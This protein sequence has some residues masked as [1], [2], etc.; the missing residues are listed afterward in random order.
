[1][2]LSFFVVTDGQKW[3]EKLKENIERERLLLLGDRV[4]VKKIS[5]QDGQVEGICV[6][7][8]RISRPSPG[9]DSNTFHHILAAN[10]DALVIVV[11]TVRP[12]F[13]AGLIDR[14]LIGAE[15]E[16][17]PVII[18]V[19]KTDLME[20]PKPWL[21]YKTLGYEVIEVSSKL[22]MG[23][24]TLCNKIE[25]KTVVFCGQSGVGKT[26]LLRSLLGV[27][28]GRVGEVNETT[29]KGRHTTTGAVLLGGPNHSRWI[30]TPGVREFG[31][32]NVTPQNLAQWFPEFHNLGCAQKS[33]P[34]YR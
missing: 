18:C 23:V 34:S 21:I 19:S 5:D 10:V 2:I 9:R 13:S 31:L 30:D 24:E 8:N 27:E 16:K 29:G 26:S 33:C 22:K 6:R 14:F 32:L 7:Q 11:S 28:I 12:E 25:G 15:L 4:L 17:I 1:M 20:S 3:L